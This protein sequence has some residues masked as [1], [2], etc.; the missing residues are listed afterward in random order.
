MLYTAQDGTLLLDDGDVL[1]HPGDGGEATLTAYTSP[2]TWKDH[3]PFG[4]PL[5]T[6][7]SNFIAV[8]IKT[9]SN[10]GHLH[11]LP[12]T[13]ARATLTLSSHDIALL[14]PSS[15]IVLF[16]SNLQVIKYLPELSKTEYVHI[17][18]G[19]VGEM[20]TAVPAYTVSASISVA[21][22]LR[23][24]G[25]T[26][27]PLALEVK[28]EV[29]SE[30][31]PSS[32]QEFSHSALSRILSLAAS[33]FQYI[34]NLLLSTCS[35]PSSEGIT[36]IQSRAQDTT[37]TSPGLLFTVAGN[38]SV[39]VMGRDAS[40]LLIL[41]GGKP[42]QITPKAIGEGLWLMDLAN[43]LPTADDAQRRMEIILQE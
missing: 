17:A 15:S 5:A 11:L 8:P 31:S 20:L 10:V 33:V 12:V 23:G 25:S 27:E 16:D 22:L 30:H 26:A 29:Q 9:K 19:P 37:T 21:F 4:V 38:P 7:T 14:A 32:G 2:S 24:P 41:V 42:L 28:P 6:Q 18:V 34:W 40:K 36:R 35:K 3:V 39:L 43:E 1:F 13:D